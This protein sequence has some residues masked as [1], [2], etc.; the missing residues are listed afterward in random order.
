M[1]DFAISG[2]AGYIAPRHL[3]AIRDTNNNLI[4]ALDPHDSVGIL[5]NY[6]PDTIYCP[7]DTSFENFINSTDKRIEYLSIC[8]PNYLHFSQILMGLKLGLNVICEKP[9]VLNLDELRTIQKAEASC[10]F[11]VSPIMQLRL[12]PSIIN[13]KNIVNSLTGKQS[14]QLTYITSRGPWYQSSWK[15]NPE[16]SGGLAM[17][18]GIHFFD[19]LLWIFGPVEKSYLHLDRPNKMAGFLEL[20]K[21]SVRWFLS[22]DRNDLPI[23]EKIKGASAFRSLKMN[24]EEYD[25]TSGFSNLHTSCYNNIVGGHGLSIEDTI[26]SIEIVT[27]LTRTE[28]SKKGMQH[29]FLSV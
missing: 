6:F 2:V 26:P 15:G 16:K 3:T 27:T 13:L 10:K 9:L 18:I 21:A 25:F 20:Q 28:L 5:D 8:S 23:T 1:T 22:V 4:V 12:H 19:I 29:P 17:A 11:R 14:V 24:D 7:D